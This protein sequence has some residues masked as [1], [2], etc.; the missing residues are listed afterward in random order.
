MW[1]CISSAAGLIVSLLFAALGISV[2]GWFH[3]HYEPPWSRK[4]GEWWKA[5][6]PTREEREQRQRGF[7]VEFRGNDKPAT[8]P[9]PS[10]PPGD[11]KM[12][13]GH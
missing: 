4:L 6:F 10:I 2:S 9:A 13:P 1:W 12:P 11:P 8:P 7:E 3:A 5:K